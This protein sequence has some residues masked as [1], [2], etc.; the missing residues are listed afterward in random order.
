M[1]I[2]AGEVERVLLAIGDAATPAA[3]RAEYTK[4]EYL[5]ILFDGIIFFMLV[6]QK[7]T[8]S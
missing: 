7:F 5:N 4:V 3:T 1:S 2:D 8:F 6:N